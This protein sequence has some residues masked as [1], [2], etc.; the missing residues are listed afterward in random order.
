MGDQGEGLEKFRAEVLAPLAE[1]A[2]REDMKNYG[3][4][5]QVPLALALACLLGKVLLAADRFAVA[6]R[7][8]SIGGADR[9][10]KKDA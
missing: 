6:R 3:E 8:P 1:T 2:A 9:W 10:T 5:F 4:L 7:L